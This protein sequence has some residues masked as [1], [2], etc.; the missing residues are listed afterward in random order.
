[1][2]RVNAGTGIVGVLVLF[3]LLS[4][5]TEQPLSTNLVAIHLAHLCLLLSCAVQTSNNFAF[6]LN[7][8][9]TICG[10]LDTRQS[11]LDLSQAWARN[12][13]SLSHVPI[14]GMEWG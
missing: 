10:H 12:G 8:G 1:V 11:Y 14:G 4:C 5:R 6:V 9:S 7:I 2:S 3:R 13:I